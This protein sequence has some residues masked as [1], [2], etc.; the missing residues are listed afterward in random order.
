[1]LTSSF[2]AHR[3]RFFGNSLGAFRG[4]FL[5]VPL[6]LSSR[7]D[8]EQPPEVGGREAVGEDAIVGGDAGEVRADRVQIS[9]QNWVAVGGLL[10]G[11]VAQ[12]GEVR[13]VLVDSGEEEAG[14]VW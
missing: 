12:H 11:L 13:N 3:F 10:D 6:E 5:D 8:V 14:L 7:F 4:D 1:M 2:S 9:R